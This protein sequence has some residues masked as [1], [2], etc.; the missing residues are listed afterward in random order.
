MR[1]ISAIAVACTLALLP[2]GAARA[3]APA[4]FDVGTAVVDITPTTPQYLGGY[5]HMDTPT[6]VAHD[7]LQV[8]AFFAGHGHDAV[9]FAIVDTQGW[10]AGY[11]EGPYGVTA[12]RQAAAAELA[13]SGYDVGPGN[14]IVSS[15]HSHAAPTIMGIWGP[16]DPAYL[17]RVHDAT[18]Q[19]I[20]A[21]AQHTRRAEL[22]TGQGSIRSLIAE[23]LE[24]TDH[25]DGWGIDDRTPV[26]WAR[27]PRTG[28]TLGLHTNVPV[29]ADQFRGSKYRQ[30]SADHPGAERAAL[31]RL[32]G[33]TAVVAM[34]TLGR[35]EA[36]GGQDDY[37]EVERQG[38]FVANAIMRGLAHARPI[39]DTHLAGAEQ[40]ISVPAHNVALL[41]LLYEN[42][43]TGFS[44]SDEIGACTIDR[45]TDPPYLVGDLVGTW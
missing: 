31:D 3:A 11:Q 16:T 10:F 13:R 43:T 40:Y 17:K 6:P 42:R 28:A 12:A 8:R 18:V 20:V 29:H 32:L 34:G 2:A 24:G 36:M 25:F 1:R 19:A 4:I 21:A 9:A 14:L 27:A 33:G 26:L 30:A 44:C 45:S 37:S 15:T 22:W 35:Q 39:T 7:P 38:R 23:N 5:D 41:A